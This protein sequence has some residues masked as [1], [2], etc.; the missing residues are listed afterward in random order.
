MTREE[1]M[2]YLDTVL[3]QNADGPPRGPRPEGTFVGNVPA[4]GVSGIRL[5]APD[6]TVFYLAAFD[7]DAF[8]RGEA[9]APNPAQRPIYETTSQHPDGHSADSPALHRTLGDAI[10]AI[11]AHA[12]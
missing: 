10:R 3:A 2:H 4:G 5:V 8:E 11:I 12:Q 1:L 7:G 9:T 6:G